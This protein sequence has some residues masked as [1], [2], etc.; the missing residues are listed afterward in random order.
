M[1]LIPPALPSQHSS[2]VNQVKYGLFKRTPNPTCGSWDVSFIINR[3]SFVVYVHQTP[4]ITLLARSSR[5]NFCEKKFPVLLHTDAPLSTPHHSSQAMHNPSSIPWVGESSSSET[6]E[7]IDNPE[8]LGAAICTPEVEKK[9]ILA[10]SRVAS[11]SI[12]K[13]KRTPLST[14]HPIIVYPFHA[15]YRTRRL[16]LITKF[17]REKR[18]R[19]S[20]NY[21]SV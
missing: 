6:S 10:R 1:D 12:K 17:D 4:I 9:P 8:S 2:L 16:P 13:H 18:K 15:E 19:C 21:K 20:L 7:E 3:D 5:Y 11:Y 14:I